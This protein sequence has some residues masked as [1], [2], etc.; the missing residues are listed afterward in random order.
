MLACSSS[1]EVTFTPCLCVPTCQ[2]LHRTQVFG[3]SKPINYISLLRKNITTIMC[4]WK[5][6]NWKRFVAVSFHCVLLWVFVEHHVHVCI[7]DALE[8]RCVQTNLTKAR[9]SMTLLHL[10]SQFNSSLPFSVWL[11]TPCFK[12]SSRT[13]TNENAPKLTLNTNQAASFSE[14]NI[15]YWW[16][17][18]IN[19]GHRR[20][21]QHL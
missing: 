16:R 19:L 13:S 6:G 11:S 10:P 14:P 7:P 15:Y 8:Y 20:I 21:S 1:A 17:C 12:R 2:H 4:N 3:Q 5:Q 18:S 9:T